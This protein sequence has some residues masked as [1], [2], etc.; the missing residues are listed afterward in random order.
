MIP[1]PQPYDRF[2]MLKDKRPWYEITKDKGF[3]CLFWD[4]RNGQQQEN[5]IVRFREAAR[6]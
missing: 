5:N 3:H 4:W 6:G 1:I 2:V